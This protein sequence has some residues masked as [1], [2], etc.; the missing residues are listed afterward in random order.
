MKLH[1]RKKQV[2]PT[3]QESLWVFLLRLAKLDYC[4]CISQ[5]QGRHLKTQFGS[6]S[7]WETLEEWSL[8]TASS[9]SPVAGLQRPWPWKAMRTVFD[10]GFHRTKS[11]LPNQVKGRPRLGARYVWI[12][13]HHGFWHTQASMLLGPSSSSSLGGWICFSAR[14]L[15]AVPGAGMLENV[16]NRRSFYACPTLPQGIWSRHKNRSS[17]LIA[18]R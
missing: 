1:D 13:S 4:V 3:Y 17:L 18:T 12:A 5:G 15:S 7:A 11:V 6:H 9:M 14:L 2:S 10:T 8:G 16:G